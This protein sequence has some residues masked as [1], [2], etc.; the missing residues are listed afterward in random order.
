MPSG[1]W[2]RGGNS[3]KSSMRDSALTSSIPFSPTS[4]R[5]ISTRAL[6]PYVLFSL[7]TSSARRLA[8][9]AV[10][11]ILTLSSVCIAFWFF[12]DVAHVHLSTLNVIPLE[13]VV[14]E[15]LAAGA[16]WL[17]VRRIERVAHAQ[18]AADEQR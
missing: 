13:I 9:R 1:I 12:S 11:L 6:L 5:C 8:T 4:I 15:S 3:T 16:T 10:V 7:A 14:V 2:T 17:I 18:N